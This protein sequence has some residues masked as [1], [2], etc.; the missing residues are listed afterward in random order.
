MPTKI[1]VHNF[2]IGK[3]IATAVSMGNWQRAISLGNK[4]AMETYNETILYGFLIV[5]YK[6]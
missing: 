4:Y 2:T 6:T 1:T 3:N 5:S